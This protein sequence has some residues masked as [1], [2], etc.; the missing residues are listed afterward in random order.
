[1]VDA[2]CQNR[3]LEVLSLK[4]CS[5]EKQVLQYITMALGMN[6]GIKSLY[7]A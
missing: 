5:I 1:M 7:L 6:K 3:I 4:G 2:L